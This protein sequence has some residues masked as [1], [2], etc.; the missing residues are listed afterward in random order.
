MKN[1]KL[2]YFLSLLLIT[3][4]LISGCSLFRRP[5]PERQPV[6][7]TPAPDLTPQN[8]NINPAPQPQEPQQQPQRQPT[9][10]TTELAERIADIA[11][12]VDGVDNSVV[13]V[14]SNMALVGITLERDS[15]AQEKEIKK[16]VAKRIEDREPSIVNAYV[17]AN[18][19]LVKQLQ[20]ISRGIQRGEPISSFFD[21][22]TDVLSRMRAE[23]N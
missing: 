1:K 17:S 4:F 8:P 9:P 22:I 6:P 13:V 11:T 15:A 18:P 14:I 20:D 3:S 2:K 7:Q 23:T 12:D 10:E 5:E 16:E 19:D 21:Q